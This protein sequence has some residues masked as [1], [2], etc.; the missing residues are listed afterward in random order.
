MLIQTGLKRAGISARKA[1]KLAG[2]SEGRWRQI[3]NGYQTVSR[4]V[5]IPVR[6]APADTVARMAHVVGIAPEQLEEADRADAAEELRAMAK[7]VSPSPGGV[8]DWIRS[9]ARAWAIWNL[10]LPLEKRI[11][12]IRDLMEADLRRAEE[13]EEELRGEAG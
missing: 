1:A 11:Q 5:H 8:P 10:D 2:I 12:G 7:Q 6:K 13:R 4:G 9:D 3:A